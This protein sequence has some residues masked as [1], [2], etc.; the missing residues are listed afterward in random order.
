ML[1]EGGLALVALGLGA[2]TGIFPLTMITWNGRG[3]AGGIAATAP[4]LLGLWWCRRTSVASV[5]R[6]VAFVETRVAPMFAGW[7]VGHLAL[8]AAMA[9]L[10]EELLF[11]GVLQPV[12]AEHVPAWLAA[13]TVGALFGLMH[14]LTPSYAV[15]AGVVGTYL[16]AVLLVSGNLLVPILAHALYDLVALLLLTRVKQTPASSVL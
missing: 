15:L 7:K 14:W 5:A 13:V 1:A 6:L 2:W 9:G 3:L 10:G 8:V 16:G 4:L 12:L 11:R